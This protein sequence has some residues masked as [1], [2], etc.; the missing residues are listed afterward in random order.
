[1]MYISYHDQLLKV[2]DFVRRSDGSVWIDCN[3]GYLINPE[4]VDIVTLV[5][6]S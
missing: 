2:H 4:H 5:T 3:I 1:M 6:L